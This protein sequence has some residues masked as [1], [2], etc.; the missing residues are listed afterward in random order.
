LVRFDPGRSRDAEFAMKTAPYKKG[1]SATPR[2]R[3]A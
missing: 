2:R 3:A 1:A